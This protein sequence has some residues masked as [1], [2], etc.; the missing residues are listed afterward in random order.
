MSRQSDAQAGECV[1]ARPGAVGSP[2]RTPRQWPDVHSVLHDIV[3][4]EARAAAGTAGHPD[5]EVA[6]LIA[7]V[8]RRRVIGGVLPTL[9]AVAAA[10][11]IG[12]VAIQGIGTAQDVGPAGAPRPAAVTGPGVDDRAP[13]LAADPTPTRE[14]PAQ[15]ATPTL[16][17]PGPADVGAPSRDVFAEYLD[18]WR[19]H[20]LERLE[21]LTAPDS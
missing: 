14:A 2:A 18:A 20:D 7:Q 3:D 1:P 11:L 17:D 5:A 12:V 9:G 6:Q 13:S 4:E 16:D 10:G 19:R 8:R 15:D 21:A